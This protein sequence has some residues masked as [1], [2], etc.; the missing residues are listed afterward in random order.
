[1]ILVPIRTG[2]GLNDRECWQARQRRVKKQRQAV[3]WVLKSATRPDI[4]CSVL[5]TRIAPSSGLDD[6][7][8]VGSLK[9][10]RDQV[11]EW[12]GVDDKHRDQVRYRYAQCRGEWGVC[13]EFGPPVAGAQH[14]LELAA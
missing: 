6:D 10:I 14:V 11:A 13:I 2:R 3:A 9:A 7:G 4:P 8:L 5:L 12:L 1:M